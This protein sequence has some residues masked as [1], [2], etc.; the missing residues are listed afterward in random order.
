MSQTIGSRRRLLGCPPGHRLLDLNTAQP[1]GRG[2]SHPGNDR[3][4][5]EFMYPVRAILIFG[6][7]H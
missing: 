6:R 4:Q 5:D 2:R 1:I 3:T 7:R